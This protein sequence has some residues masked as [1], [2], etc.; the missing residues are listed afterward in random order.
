MAI[1]I[2]QLINSN[3]GIGLFSTIAR[4]IPVQYGHRLA[5]FTADR[6]ATHSDSRLVRAVRANQWVISGEKLDKQDLDQA[7]RDTF[8]NSARSIFDLYHYLPN[9][10]ATKRLVV[11]NDAIQKLAK[12]PELGQRGLMVVGL[13][14]SNFDLVLR[15][16]TLQGI[17]PLILTIP[18]P[19]GSQRVEYEIRRKTGM[20]LVPTSLATLR[21]ALKYLQQGGVVMT[22]IDRPIPQPKYRPEFFGRPADLPTHHVYLA[23]KAHVPVMIIVTIWKPGGKNYVFTSDLIEMESHPDQNTEI[24][25][26]AGKVLSVGEEFIRQAPRQWGMTLPVWPEALDQMPV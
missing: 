20:N 1:D 2:Q 26:N 3:F 5:N 9:P 24:L 17:R 14:I 21:Q 25:R 7:V 6:I 19:R 18:D 10:A 4:L 11:F 13:H 16:F 23:A 15:A 22:G 12:R 8:R